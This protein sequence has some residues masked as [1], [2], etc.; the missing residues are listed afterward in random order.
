[1]KL[2]GLSVKEL[3]SLEYKLKNDIAHAEESIITEQS[4]L[5]GLKHEIGQVRTRRRQLEYKERL[6]DEFINLQFH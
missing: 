1:M 4:R 6:R 5:K 3:K 2:K